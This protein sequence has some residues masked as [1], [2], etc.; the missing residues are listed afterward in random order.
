MHLSP[1]NLP[2]IKRRCILKEEGHK[3]GQVSFKFSAKWSSGF[4]RSE[5]VSC[6]EFLTGSSLSE[7]N[8]EGAALQENQGSIPLFDA[9]EEAGD[10]NC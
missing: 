2:N 6:A 9:V 8:G 1:P 4:L 10:V 7:A 5:R 3:V